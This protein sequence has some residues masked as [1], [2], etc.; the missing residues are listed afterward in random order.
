MKVKSKRRISIPFSGSSF[1]ENYCFL[2][3]YK[4]RSTKIKLSLHV[5]ADDD[6]GLEEK[7]HVLAE[8]KESNFILN[9][10]MH[11]FF[12]PCHCCYLTAATK[13][14]SAWDDGRG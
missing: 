9:L 6:N 2:N 14:L 7:I 8:V 3:S 10:E 4:S 12:M 1:Q 13:C 5:A 11:L